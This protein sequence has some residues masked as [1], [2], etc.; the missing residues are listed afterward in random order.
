M[1]WSLGAAFATVSCAIAGVPSPSADSTDTTSTPTSIRQTD[2]H[3]KE[4]PFTTK[5]PDRWSANNDG[6]TYEPC[7]S[8]TDTELSALGVDPTTVKDVALANHQTARGCIW[9]YRGRWMG[10]VSHFTGDKPTFE[11]EKKDRSWYEKSYDITIDGRLVLVDYWDSSRCI[12]TVEV[13]HASVST[14]VTRL[15]NPPP[16]SELCNLA[17][18]FTKLTLPKMPPPAP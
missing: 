7:T 12:T 10:G 18:E 11:E 8:L 2:D 15:W 5:F 4:L 3:G 9:S 14:I 17:I 16:E 13:E 6:T 1:L